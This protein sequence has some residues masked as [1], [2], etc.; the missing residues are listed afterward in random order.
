MTSR[1]PGL[2]APWRWLVAPQWL[3]IHRP[4]EFRTIVDREK[5]RVDRNNHM[6]CLLSLSMD[7][8]GNRMRVN[9]LVRTASKRLR[10]TDVIGWIDEHR[11]GIILPDTPP[12]GARTV[13]SSICRSLESDVWHPSWDVY[14]YPPDSMRP[15]A[16]A[17]DPRQLLLFN[18]SPDTHIMSSVRMPGAEYVE[19]GSGS[20]LDRAL[21]LPCPWWKR[22]IDMVGAAS[23]LI[24][25][26]PLLAAC[27]VAIKIA[28]PG[29][30]FLRQERIGFLGRRFWC[31][32]L[33][34]MKVNADQSV[35]QKHLDH[36]IR[37]NAAMTKLDKKADPR[38]IPGIGRI[39]RAS[40]ID[41]LP[42]LLN[43]VRGDMSLVGPRP[44]LPY[45]YAMY[46]RWHRQRFN[47]LPGLTGLWQVSGKNRT[48]FVDMMR[49]DIAY[50]QSV[51]PWKDSQILLRTF[52]AVVTEVKEVLSA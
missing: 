45:E 17:E 2:K 33:R 34:T 37:S 20:D 19:L 43:V 51:T 30:V 32:K 50:S 35:H 47:S 27:V 25:L 12:T 16:S 14:V 8:D 22:A 48:S 29:P 7:D 42:Q 26:S 24:L 31:L 28:S 6:F 44:C 21:A 5:A 23:A 4:N 41:E 13:G 11:I 1:I 46:Q 15:R 40:G 9:A 39:L 10:K 52:P 38:L 18:L 36:L 49:L 3:G